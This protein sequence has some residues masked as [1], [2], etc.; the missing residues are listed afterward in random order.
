MRPVAARRPGVEVHRSGV[1]EDIG[2]RRRIGD[3]A[4]HVGVHVAI[5]AIKPRALIVTS[6]QRSPQEIDAALEAA[7]IAA[8]PRIGEGGVAVAECLAE[9]A[10]PDRG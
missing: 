3:E 10:A 5:G 8:C 2:G 1:A 4:V 9:K 6:D 7:E